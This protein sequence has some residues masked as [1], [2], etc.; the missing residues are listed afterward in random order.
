M[1][2]SHGL[3][4]AVG[5]GGPTFIDVAGTIVN[6]A[7]SVSA[8]LPSGIAAGDLLVMFV[9]IATAT[10]NTIT[11]PSGWTQFLAQVTGPRTGAY[12][13]VADGS[14]GATQSV[15]LSSG[16]NTASFN[17]LLIRG[18]GLT[19]T[20]GAFAAS[21]TTSPITNAGI[22][23]TSSGLLLG[24]WGI[25]ANG[26]SPITVTGG[27]SGMSLAN[28]ASGYTGNDAMTN[29]VYYQDWAA[30]ATGTREITT[31]GSIDSSRSLLLQIQ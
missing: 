16:G 7:S 10:G 20:V 8:N 1:L 30:T 24:F 2:I 6:S 23:P 9:S 11:T 15:T 27:P 29:A 25:R 17:V 19:Y 22:T 21:D 31:S 14:E 4:A 3:R 26:T 18:Q 13:K 5:G 12:Y 28:I